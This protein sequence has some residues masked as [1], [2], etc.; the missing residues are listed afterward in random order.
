MGRMAFDGQTIKVA[1]TMTQ[2]D[3]LDDLRNAARKIIN[4][5]DDILRCQT[6]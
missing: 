6:T 3:D 5:I 4:A 1:L 2:D